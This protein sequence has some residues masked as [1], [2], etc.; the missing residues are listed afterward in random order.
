MKHLV[1]IDGVEKYFYT[2]EQPILIL[3][4]DEKKYICKYIHSQGSREKLICEYLSWS[5]AD[6][7]QINTPSYAFVKFKVEHAPFNAKIGHIQTTSIGS[8]QIPNVIDV[9]PTT[10]KYIKPTTSL[11]NDFLKIAYFDLLTSNED[12]NSNNANL[13]YNISEEE[14]IAI[15]FGCTF[16]T[17][18]FDMPL[19]LLTTNETI[20]NSDL[21][22][23][24]SSRY[25]E[26]TVLREAENVVQK[27]S[28]TIILVNQNAKAIIESIP[29]DWNPDLELV[30]AKVQELLSSEWIASVQDTFFEYLKDN[31]VHE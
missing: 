31:I 12:R 23:H 24:I 21:F 25:K 7:M 30:K 26:S 27:M 10:Y 2:G 13:L 8:Q 6:L 14:I 16:N 28:S 22:R 15:D 18:T 9:V 3:C 5:F 4:S 17:A 20:L 19:S 11:L 29:Q 1:S